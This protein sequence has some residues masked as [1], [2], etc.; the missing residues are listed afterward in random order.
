MRSHVTKIARLVLQ[1]LLILGISFLLGEITVRTYHYFNPLF[2]FF[3]D[4]YNRFRGRPF[5][6]DWD[7][8]LN[9]Q[10]FKDTEFGQKD[11]DAYRIL[12]IGDSFAYGVVPY[13]YNYLTLLE[14]QLRE[15][16]L[17]AE[18]FNMGIPSI[19]PKDYFSLLIREGLQ[20]RP[21]MVLLSFFIGNDILESHRDRKWYSY[22]YVASLI[23]YMVKIRPKYEGRI[24]HGKNVY[25]DTCPTFAPELYLQIESD[26][27]RIYMTADADTPPFDEALDC[28]RQLRDVCRKN[29]IDLVVVL[30]P[31]EVQI[32]DVLQ[33]EVRNRLSV[34]QSRWNIQLPNNILTAGLKEMGVDYVDLYPHFVKEAEENRLYKP[35]DTH[36]NIAGNQFAAD[37]ISNHLRGYVTK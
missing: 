4:S 13:A 18:V 21:D 6:Y 36:W 25:C 30:I 1:G 14:S 12:G 28:L 31:D 9:S 8:K 22:S 37:I 19:G 7:F 15:E 27:S 26:R 24:I 11:D 20:L 29:G 34:N 5:S 17:R 33:R 3:D 16:G 23:H 2:I 32:N 10:G 35:R